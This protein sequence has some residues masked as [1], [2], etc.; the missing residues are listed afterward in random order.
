MWSKPDKETAKENSF[1][2]TPLRTFCMR[3]VSSYCIPGFALRRAQDVKRNPKP[4]ENLGS[5]D[6]KSLNP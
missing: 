4:S 2:H 3:P 6:A 1:T 5:L